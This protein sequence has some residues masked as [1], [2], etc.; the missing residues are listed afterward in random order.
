MKHFHHLLICRSSVWEVRTVDNFSISKKM[1]VM[2]SFPMLFESFL[3]EFI[4]Q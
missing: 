3:L 2:H 4:L 1:F